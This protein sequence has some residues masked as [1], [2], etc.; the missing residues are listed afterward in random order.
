MLSHIISGVLRWNTGSKHLV[1]GME[2]S[3]LGL[4]QTQ[5]SPAALIAPKHV[6]ACL[7]PWDTNILDKPASMK[8]CVGF[9]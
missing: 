3:F 1:Y 6:E 9:I 8:A 4:M 7:Y 2:N 5:C